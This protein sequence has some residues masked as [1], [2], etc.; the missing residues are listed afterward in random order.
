MS[1]RL[2]ICLSV[3]EHISGT[4]G[5][6]FTKFVAQIHVAV[7]Q[8]SSGGVA[9]SE[10]GVMSMNA[11]LLLLGR[12]AVVAQRPI[13]IKLSRGRSV[14]YCVEWDVKP[15]STQLDL[16]VGAS[17]C[18]V[19][20]GKTADRIRMPFGIIGRTGAVMRQVWGS[21]YGNWYFWGEFGARHCNQW[22]LYGVC[23]RQCRVAALFPN[24]F[25]QTCYYYKMKKLHTCSRRLSVRV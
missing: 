5:P 25:G 1:V 18:P 8:S 17:V 4:A 22:G 11:L 16:S 20:C 10:R 6:T 15:Y 21:V 13:V 3:R 24:Y 14:L 9:I 12:V 7:T 23:V 2:C 19:H